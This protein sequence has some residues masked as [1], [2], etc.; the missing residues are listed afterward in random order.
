VVFIRD[1]EGVENDT[2]IDVSIICGGE[3]PGFCEILPER[4]IDGKKPGFFDSARGARN[5]VFARYFLRGL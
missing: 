4:L 3:K 2:E 1:R 5:R